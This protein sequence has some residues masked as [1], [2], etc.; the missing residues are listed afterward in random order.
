MGHQSVRVQ[1]NQFGAFFGV[2][3]TIYFWRSNIKG[4]HESSAKALHIMQITTVMVVALLIWCPLTLLLR[5]NVTLPPPP[6]MANLHM[7]EESL[8][9]LN[10]SF[11]TQIMA[12]MLVVGF[13]HSLLA[14][15]G[16]E[17]L[18]Q[19]YREIES[20]KLKKPAHRRQPRIRV[21][22]SLP[23]GNRSLG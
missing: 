5:G 4:I 2:A 23:A 20:P 13:G 3:V 8:G 1:P 10:G 9:W 16:F 19:V 21:F 14:M 18:V 15:S 6:T 17:T 11:L 22:E 7:T 12:V